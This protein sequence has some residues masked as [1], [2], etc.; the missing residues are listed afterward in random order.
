MTY[1]NGNVEMVCRQ[2]EEACRPI[3]DS[4]RND[5]TTCVR[6]QDDDYQAVIKDTAKSAY[7]QQTPSEAFAVYRCLAE[8]SAVAADGDRVSTET[9]ALVVAALE[10]VIA[11]ARAQTVTDIHARINFIEH[12]ADL[13]TQ[14]GSVAACARSLRQ[15][16]YALCRQSIQIT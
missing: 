5:S 8:M 13:G 7:P 16:L 3:L 1:S 4:W 15:D 2:I 9:R 12:A 14:I 6:L 10:D 11:T